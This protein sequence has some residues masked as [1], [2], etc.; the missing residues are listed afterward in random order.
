V[1]VVVR[2]NATVARGEPTGS[3]N[4]LSSRAGWNTSGTPSISPG[5]GRMSFTYGDIGD[6]WS[7]PYPNAP[8]AENTIEYSF[9]EPSRIS[10]ASS[11][12]D[13]RASNEK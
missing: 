7:N 8:S 10:A 3:Q 9:P 12:S 11:V 2:Q 6:S 13:H 4:A 5:H 1:S